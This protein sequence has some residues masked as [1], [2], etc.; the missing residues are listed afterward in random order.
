MVQY[1]RTNHGG[2]LREE[3]LLVDVVCLKHKKGDSCIVEGN[4][5][6]V[7]VSEIGIG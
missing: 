6:F 4:N 5:Q 2:A 1:I 7:S 3:S